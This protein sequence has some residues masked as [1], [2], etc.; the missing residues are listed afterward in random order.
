MVN[1]KQAEALEAFAKKHDVPISDVVWMIIEKI[2]WLQQFGLKTND[3][4][5]WKQ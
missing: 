1:R 3:D 2:E 4:L 5:E